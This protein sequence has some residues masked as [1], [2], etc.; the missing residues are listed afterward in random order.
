MNVSNIIITIADTLLGWT[1]LYVAVFVQNVVIVE[2]LLQLGA[3][4]FVNHYLL[5]Y[6]VRED[7]LDMIKVLVKY[8]DNIDIRNASGW[9]PLLIAISERNIPIFKFFIDNGAKLNDN[10][11]LKELHVAIMYCTEATEFKSIAHTLLSKNV[12]VN[13][14]NYWG[15][16]P[17]HYTILQ[18]KYEMTEY[19]IKEGADVNVGHIAR[20]TDNLILARHSKNVDLMKLLGELNHFFFVLCFVTNIFCVLLVYAGLK[21]HGT[22]RP[23]SLQPPPWSND[24]DSEHFLAKTSFNTLSLQQL[25]RITIRNKIIEKMKGTSNAQQFNYSNC[26]DKGSIMK[27]LLASLHLPRSIQRYLY[28]FPDVPQLK[29]SSNPTISSISS[30]EIQSSNLITVNNNF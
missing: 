21:V 13:C 22:F 16:T 20:S 3:R 1:P 2:R 7:L 8:G 12:D 11:L 30:Y 27:N 15:E 17:L 4:L 26:D 10:P 23:N 25:T 28:D 24:R 14:V 18:E 5:H 6:C 19:L 9:S 29:N